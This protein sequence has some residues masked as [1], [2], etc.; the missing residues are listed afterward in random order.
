[1]SIRNS[2]DGSTKPWMDNKPD[3]RQLS[4]VIEP[5]FDLDDKT[6]ANSP[7]IYQ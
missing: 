4:D 3:S 5:W 7:V 6:L 1:M 2:K